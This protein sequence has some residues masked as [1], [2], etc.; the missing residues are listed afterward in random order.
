MEQ[1]CWPKIPA[2]GARLRNLRRAR[3][4]KQSALAEMI[5]VE[6]STVSRWESGTLTPSSEMQEQVFQSLFDCKVDEFALKLLVES[7]TLATHLIDEASHVC[8]A[9][10]KPRGLEWRKD[11][12][13]LLGKTLWPYASEE[14][15]LAEEEL[16][17]IGW[18][19]TYQPEPFKIRTAPS[20]NPEMRIWAGY[21]TYERMYLANG[22]PVRLCTTQFF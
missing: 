20:D 11:P 8:L 19:D 1:F 12:Q 14:I 7:S 4:L 5:G 15:Q 2:F 3:S 9:F 18:W 17:K 10:S 22:T 13:T 21:L 6:Q 16:G